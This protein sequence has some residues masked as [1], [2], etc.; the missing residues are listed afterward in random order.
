MALIQ[1]SDLFE[2]EQMKLLGAFLE[3]CLLS[4]HLARPIMTPARA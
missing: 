1:A 4:A 2:M 3:N